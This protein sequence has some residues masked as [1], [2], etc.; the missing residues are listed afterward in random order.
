MVQ[1]FYFLISNQWKELASLL[2]DKFSYTEE[3]KPIELKVNYSFNI[4][5]CM[6]NTFDAKV[7]TCPANFYN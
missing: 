2:R 5:D 4:L 3:R 1:V 7:S 6:D